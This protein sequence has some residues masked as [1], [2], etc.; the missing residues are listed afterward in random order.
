[1]RLHTGRLPYQ[2]GFKEVMQD[3]SEFAG[4]PDNT[5]QSWTTWKED[6]KDAMQDNR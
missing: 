3:A 5:V 2:I 4:T 1:M 6:I